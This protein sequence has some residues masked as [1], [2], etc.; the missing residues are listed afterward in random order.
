[1][2]CFDSH[3]FLS[4]VHLL[5]SLSAVYIEQWMQATL[6]ARSISVDATLTQIVETNNNECKQ[7]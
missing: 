4:S 2:L 7:T 5:R 3:W 1:M 6:D